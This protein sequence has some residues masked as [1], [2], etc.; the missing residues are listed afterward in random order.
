[1]EWLFRSEFDAITSIAL[2]SIAAVLVTTVALFVYTLGL[3]YATWSSDM[4]RREFLARWRDVFASAAL[5]ENA[6]ESIEL[7][8]VRR[9]DHTDLLEEWN[10]AR[11]IVDGAAADNLIVLANRVGI[12]K[13][14]EELF[15]QR[16][17]QSKIM[18]VQTFGHLRQAD[19]FE[20]IQALLDHP[21]TALSI[22]AAT[23]LI[24]IDARRGIELVMPKIHVRRDW[25]R[26]RVSILLREAGSDLV[27]EPMYRAIR[28]ASNE[29]RTY[30]L[31]FARLMESEVRDAL[32]EELIRESNDAGLV[33]SALKL[34]SGYRG[35]PRIAA[36]TQHDAWFVR[37]QSAKVLGRVGQREHLGI[38][39]SMLDD[40]EWWVR[41][42]AAQS[43]VS[44]PFLGPNELRALQERQTDKFA[45]DILQ[46][47]FAEAGLV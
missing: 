26:N 2:W 40:P 16:S 35:V 37:M 6:A 34:V 47:S 39:E 3:R 30:L 9:S 7:P 28:S 19:F 8:P 17:V 44:L 41:Y 4:R 43:I 29:D 15:Q 31:Q 10:R 11:S 18:A 32:V 46:Q 36:L 23:S 20:P 24:E 25:P 12:G 22:T 5:D 14:A 38:L 45:V 1:M 42:R 21:N 33:T 13:L 27:S